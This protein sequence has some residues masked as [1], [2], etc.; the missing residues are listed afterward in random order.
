MRERRYLTFDLNNPR[1]VEALRLFSAQPDKIRSEFVIDCILKTQQEDHM[2]EVIRQT[3]IN[4]LEGFS[5]HVSDTS[6]TPSKLQ[7]TEN[8]SDI[9]QALLFA[10]DD[11]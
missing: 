2:E 9:P 8:I 1:H 6:K 10:M 5:L 11:I 4:V 7:S 3:I